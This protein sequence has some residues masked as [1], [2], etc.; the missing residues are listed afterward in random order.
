MRLETF[1]GISSNVEHISANGTAQYLSTA[2]GVTDIPCRAVSLGASSTNQFAI[3]VGAPSVVTSTVGYPLEAGA[4]L[5]MD[6]D[7][8]NRI[9]VAGS[10]A[11]VVSWIAIN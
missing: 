9:Q 2:G 7:N 10:A 11:D 4:S 6:V 5:M 1:T 8:V 3:H